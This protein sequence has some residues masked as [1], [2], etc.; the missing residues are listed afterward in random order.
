MDK[1]TFSFLRNVPLFADLPDPSLE[2][3][4]QQTNI[5]TLNRGDVLFT[6]GDMGK[7]AYIIKEGEIEVYKTVNGRP[8]QLAIRQP[9]DV[10]GEIS[11][12]ES[13]PRNASGKALA[14]S[15]LIEISQAQ[16]DDL[17]SF[18]PQAARTMLHTV[19]VRLQSTEMLLRQNEKMAQLGTFTA[20]I[21]H[22]LNNP[23]AA[24]MRGSDQLKTVLE[25]FRHLTAGPTQT[26]VNQDAHDLLQAYVHPPTQPMDALQRS[27]LETKIEEWLDGNGIENSWELAPMLTS[28]GVDLNSLNSFAAQVSPADLTHSLNLA[29]IDSELDSLVKEINQG[30][31]QISAIVKALKSYVYLDQAP[32]QAVD[33]HEGLEDTLIIL[34]HKLKQGVTIQREYD[35]SIPR[36][37]AFGSELNQVW[38][39]L[40][41]NAVDAMEGK[42]QIILRTRRQDPWT[43]VEIEDTGPGIPPE[44]Q[45]RLFTPFFT[46]KPVGKGT[47]L[48][49]NI[50]YNII[51]KH[52]GEIKVI[53]QP[54]QTRIQVWLPLDDSDPAVPS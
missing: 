31:D 48:G 24:V 47:G 42:G 9:R 16:F 30:A 11:L 34:R 17:I 3:I 6:E 52:L 1:D 28:L 33:I 26:R 21:A 23:A 39:N 27:D 2:K 13:A 32:T 7:Q 22:E 35:R 8:V 10:I 45:A 25:K 44:I 46:T 40:I 14:N 49:L 54:G 18:S 37:Q 12:L 50:S 43:V 36:I 51:H 20:G 41:D 19:T 15:V 53:S 4:C 38:T 5:I 29:G